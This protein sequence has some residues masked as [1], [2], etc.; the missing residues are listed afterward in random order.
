[1]ATA[2]NVSYT[3]D[4]DG[5]RTSKTVNGVTHTYVYA[6]GKLLRETYGD[7]TLDFFYSTSGQPYALS[8]N[9]TI[10]YYITNLQG[11]VMSIV[12]GTG[13]VVVSYK[14]DPYG[15]IISATGT[16]AEINPLR[17]R[18]Y[19]Y[20]SECNLYYL[21][22]RYYDP[23]IGR[24]INADTFASTGQGVLGNNMFAYCG[25]N[26]V[27][28]RD[29]SGEFWVEEICIVSTVQEEEVDGNITYVTTITYTAKRP[30]IFSLLGMDTQRTTHASLR[31]TVRKNGVV[32]FDN[33]QADASHIRIDIIREVLAGQMLRVARKQVDGALSGRS[34]S[35]LSLELIDHYLVYA[36]KIPGI[37]D[38]A[39]VADMGGVSKDKPGYDSNASFFE[40]L[41]WP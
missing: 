13:A 3:Y 25:N 34:V 18:G 32:A 40:D 29:V 20:D 21:Q 12:D 2:T 8:H 37:V 10:Y 38:N 17:Y 28:R 33:A 4:S 16:L 36:H 7:T 1:M 6:S 35:G 9:G 14:Y 41:V 27:I 24:F 19:I 23:S 31:F 39:K 22:S 30:S 15:N 11:D 5:I 26:P